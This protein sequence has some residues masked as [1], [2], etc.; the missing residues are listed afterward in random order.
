MSSNVTAPKSKKNASLVPGGKIFVSQNC[1]IGVT[2][3]PLGK[4]RT[5]SDM[6]LMKSAVGGP[7][8]DVKSASPAFVLGIG[9]II[10]LSLTSKDLIPFFA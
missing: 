1:L 9:E 5:C 3:L 4:T 7:V 10:S 6:I 2:T 8:T